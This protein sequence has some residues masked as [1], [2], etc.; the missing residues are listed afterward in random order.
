M[1]SFAKSNSQGYACSLLAGRKK[2]K[3]QTIRMVFVK[4]LLSIEEHSV[5]A[6]CRTWLSPLASLLLNPYGF[7]K[8][9]AAC[10]ID[11]PRKQRYDSSGQEPCLEGIALFIRYTGWSDLALTCPSPVPTQSRYD[12]ADMMDEGRSMHACKLVCC[13][14]GTRQYQ[15]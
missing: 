8:A 5:Q 1:Q 13:L 2:G 12:G 3:Q 15:Y 14:C 10:H 9:A 11:T 7:Y 6:A 4:I